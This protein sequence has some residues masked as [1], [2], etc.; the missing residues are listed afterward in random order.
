MAKIVW[1]DIALADLES[2]VGYIAQDSEAY[3][4]AFAEKVVRIVEQIGAFPSIGR[5][6]PEYN[7]EDLHE[8]LFQNYR[9]IY[10]I[11]S[12]WVAIAAVVHA[13]RDLLRWYSP[14]VWDVV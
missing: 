13:S 3:A 5:V 7:R 9:I 14:E 8:C 6:V 12:E 2:I 10:Q 1:S 11:E 4:A